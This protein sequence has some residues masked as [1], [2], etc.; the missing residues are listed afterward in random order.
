MKTKLFLFMLFI[1]ATVTESQ[2]IKVIISGGTRDNKFNYVYVSNSTLICRGP[3]NTTCPVDLYCA[4]K[5]VRIV[6]PSPA[7][8]VDFVSGL[9][10]EGKK[11]GSTILKDVQVSWSTE[12]DD[13]LSVNIEYENGEYYLPEGMDGKEIKESDDGK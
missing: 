10:M 6:R 2:A 1:L 9:W 4:N 8:V 12:N 7:E 5:N 13:E 3:G 11:S